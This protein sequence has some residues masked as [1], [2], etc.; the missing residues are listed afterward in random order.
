MA[1]LN[2]KSL[3]AYLGTAEASAA[4]AS[5]VVDGAYD[6][7]LTQK[8]PCAKPRHAAALDKGLALLRA[9]ILAR[10]GATPDAPSALAYVRA[11]LDRDLALYDALAAK[12]DGDIAAC[13]LPE[14]T[15]L[16]FYRGR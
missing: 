10:F 1:A 16:G 14:E 7:E 6:V 5:T 3:A 9:N 15:R 4:L 11:A 13:A 8:R 12:L 2:L